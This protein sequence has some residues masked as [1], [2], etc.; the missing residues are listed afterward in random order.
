M[1]TTGLTLLLGGS[2]APPPRAPA[3][4]DHDG[5]P[6]SGDACPGTPAG[7]AVDSR[8]CA[9]PADSDGDGV[10]DDADACPGTAAGV[11][12]DATGCPRDS[13]GDGVPNSRDQCPDTPAGAAVD[14]RG[15][16]P[17]PPKPLSFNLSMTFA[18]NSAE[19]T[20]AAFQDMLK[21][22]NFLRQHPS[23]SAVVEGYTDSVG[24]ADY[25][26]DLS[27]RRA[28]AVVQALVNSG[29]DRDRLTARGYGESRPIASN[30]TEAG[31]AQNRRITVVVSETPTTPSD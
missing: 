7:S 25:N 15:C 23:V 1:F 3:D 11:A 6:D 12:V 30:D 2:S 8:G 4:S 22:L 21:V 13:D 28:N 26:R 31:R 10:A 14:E 18:F 20:G 19:I 27:L 9:E 29:I 24:P 5:V 16:P 17:K